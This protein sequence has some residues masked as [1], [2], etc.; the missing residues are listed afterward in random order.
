MFKNIQQ[1]NEF[2]ASR[3]KFGIKPGLDRIHRLLDLL[4]N[5]QH[6]IHAIHVAGTNGKGST[7][8]FLKD[9]LMYNNYQ[10]GVFTSP[11]LAGLT[12]HILIDNQPIPEKVLIALLNDIHPIIE[13]LDCESEHPTEFEILTAI[14]FVYFSKHVDIAL[15]ETGMGGREDTTNCFI[16]IL[17]IITNVARDHMGF[18]GNSIKEIACHKAG[19]IKRQIP[20]IVGEMKEDAA[21]VIKQEAALNKA[22]LLRLGNDFTIIPIKQKATKQY[23]E[24]QQGLNKLNVMLSMYGEHQQK[25]AALAIMALATMQKQGYAIAWDKALEGIQQSQIPGRFE[26]VQENP[27]VIIDGAHNVAGVQL[28][29]KTVLNNFPDKERHLVFAGFHDK[30]LEKMLMLLSKYFKTVTI[31]TFNHPR[32]QDAELLFTSAHIE[33]KVL[34]RDWLH[35]IEKIKHSTNDNRCFF[36]TGSLHFIG[37]VRKCFK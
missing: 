35:A 10:V 5:P 25:N 29:I 3:K 9:A 11:S 28:F 26:L 14:M 33:N 4:D 22:P 20:V 17:S 32:A 1:V 2:F 15:I 34:D 37:E 30:E 16:P 8:N 7:I 31:T 18:L 6:S 12:G 27:D 36:I 24:W 21:I 13:Q 19:I 23:F